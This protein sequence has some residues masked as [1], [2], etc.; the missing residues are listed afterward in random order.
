[1]VL[2][3]RLPLLVFGPALFVFLGVAPLFFKHTPEFRQTYWR[4]I[5]RGLRVVLRLL[6]IEVRV[7]PQSLQRL[8]ED[9]NS[10]IAANHKSHLDVV[11]LLSIMPDEKWVTFSPKVE[12]Y[13][14]PFFARGFTAAGCIPIDRDNPRAALRTLIKAVSEKP[15]RES[16]ILF[17]EGT[18]WRGEGVGP[19]KAGVML[20]AKAQ[21]RSVRPICIH[22]SDKLLPPGSAWPKIGAI[23]IEVLP[24]FTPDEAST[25]ENL[26]RL[27]REVAEAHQRLD[28]QT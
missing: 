14:I 19:F 10:V 11:A 18:R 27:Q 6:S 24:S 13:K 28:A 8:M 1:M 12:L 15:A 21:K 26:A 16:L 23:T 3:K 25:D 9:E 2:L 4:W 5:K 17:P 7:S 20:V 22:G